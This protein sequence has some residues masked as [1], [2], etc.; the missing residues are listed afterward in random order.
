MSM[1]DILI[2]LRAAEEGAIDR[3]ELRR[4]LAILDTWDRGGLQPSSGDLLTKQFRVDPTKVR[5]WE[6]E[7]TGQ[8]QRRIG[9][10]QLRRKV[11]Q[12]GMG[13]VFEALDPNLGRTVALKLLSGERLESPVAVQRFLRE[14]KSSG[15]FNHPNIV[16]AFDAGIDG[17]L[18]Y[19]VMEFVDGENLYQI[20]KRRGRIPPGEGVAWMVQAARAL[21]VLERKRWVHGDVKPSNF[22]LTRSGTVKLADLGLCGP[23]GKPRPGVSPHGTP[24]YIA[25]EVLASDY[26]DHRADLYSLG[27]TFY[28]LI[29]GRP[30]RLSRSIDAL[31]EEIQEPVTP[32]TEVCPE[33]S[34][35][36]S[37]LIMRLL[38]NDPARRVAGGAALLKKLEPLLPEPIAPH[39]ETLLEPAPVVDSEAPRRGVWWALGVAVI[40]VGVAIGFIAGPGGGDGGG[41]ERTQENSSEEGGAP[42]TPN[43]PET[44]K[45]SSPWAAARSE[46]GDDFVALFAWLNAEGAEF[47][48][49]EE[50]RGALIAELSALAADR[51][52]RCVLEVGELRAGSQFVAA[53]TRLEQFPENLRAGPYAVAWEREREAVRTDRQGALA[54]LLLRMESARTP[55]GALTVW[56]QLSPASTADAEWFRRRLQAELAGESFLRT[57]HLQAIEG[58]IERRNRQDRI[59][60]VLLAGQLPRSNFTDLNAE[61]LLDEIALAWLERHP[62]VAGTAG[63][64][65]PR[66]FGASLL[67]TIDP[68]ILS[69]LLARTGERAD[70]FLEVE[71]AQWSAWADAS[72]REF[73]L[74]EADEAWREL[75]SERLRPTIAAQHVLP[76]VESL[77]RE[78]RAAAFLRSD[79][80]VAEVTGP[81]GEPP[82]FLWR[83]N[84]PRLDEEWR[85]P[86][87]RFQ[88]NSRGLQARGRGPATVELALP[89]ES[90]FLIEIEWIP[91]R[92]RW[93]FSIARGGNVLGFAGVSGNSTVR[94]VAGSASEVEPILAGG[95]GSP[96]SIPTDG[97]GTPITLAVEYRDGTWDFGRGQI[98]FPIAE[99]PPP[100]WLALSLPSGGT[101]LSVRVVGT[102][103]PPWLDAR[104][105]VF[106]ERR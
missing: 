46:F 88:R 25:P 89:L 18:P 44:A 49:A 74:A 21:E 23:P 56:R 62:Q 11:G 41:G 39:D 15:S 14:A 6:R 100:G 101:L 90:R 76:Q 70:A 98:S 55:I 106:D 42:E 52:E 1:E 97:K 99:P 12:G 79:A 95:R 30:P 24:P 105:R 50:W 83:G 80:I 61:S 28:H 87:N 64:L 85:W 63:D 103:V 9:R 57:V 43:R 91:P 38:Q 45:G 53:V 13:L 35:K 17:D 48:E 71:A 94:T 67:G 32:L 84:D 96:L 73:N 81:W 47:A 102:V 65:L 29:A 36:L 31:R 7:I 59:G 86:S 54:Q 60:S 26:I 10:Y 27:T 93:M 8:S 20:L 5:R 69:L 40:L 75:S 33:V 22:I 34:P 72:C 19:L 92:E 4:L 51:W 68:T 3:E 37:A 77:R 104:E 58:S 2:A 82:T 78:L 16:H 66:L